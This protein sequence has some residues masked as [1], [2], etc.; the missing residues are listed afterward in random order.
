M[1][2]IENCNEIYYNGSLYHLK[3][4]GKMT[5]INNFTNVYLETKNNRTIIISD[6][7]VKNLPFLVDGYCYVF[8]TIEKGHL[9]E[10][11]YCTSTKKVMSNV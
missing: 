5:F 4:L 3:H 6:K 8:R 9:L 10:P 1:E 2:V 11:I 7:K